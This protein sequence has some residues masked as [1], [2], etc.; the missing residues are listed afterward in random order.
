[1]ADEPHVTAVGYLRLVGLGG[2]IGIPAALV[3]AVFLAL[4][5]D[6]EHWLWHDLPDALGH[7]SPPWYLVIGLPMAGGALVA[8]VRLVLPGD[9]GHRPLDGIAMGVTPLKHGPGIALAGLASLS[10]GAV[11][12]PEAPLIAIGAVVG[13]SVTLLFRVGGREEGVLATAGSFSAISALFGGPLVGGMLM[14]EGGLGMGAALLPIILPGFVAAAVGYLIFVGFG[15]WGGLNAQGL[16]VPNL[17]AYDGTHLA[18]L[19]VAIV[20]GILGALVVVAARR[21]ASVLDGRAR[22]DREIPLLLA[23]G[24]L[25]VGLLAQTA[26]W[27]GADSQDV[28]FSGQASV[29]DL[30]AVDSTKIVLILF[31]AKAIAYAVSLGCGFRGGPVFPAIFLGIAL[32]TFATVWFDVSPTLAVAVGAAAGTAAVTRLLVTSSL[33]ATLLVGT[34]G[35]DAVPA[36]VLAACAAWLVIQAVDRRAATSATADVVS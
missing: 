12:G 19:I 35:V 31:I 36:A 32:A 22:S 11:L 7:S 14:V 17:P 15:T 5:H 1:M 30:I 34:Q 10:F 24:G 21:A 4:V 2:L 33:F 26:D 9:G 27:L 13:L 18:D 6:I 16:V 28:L 25:A 29:P 8:L 3:A 20:V 23:A